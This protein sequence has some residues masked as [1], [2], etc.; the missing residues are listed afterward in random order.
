MGNKYDELKLNNYFLNENDIKDFVFI[1]DTCKKYINLIEIPSNKL[2]IY[3]RL[4]ISNL[5]YYSKE[6]LFITYDKILKM[7]NIKITKE[8]F[9]F[10]ISNLVINPDNSKIKMSEYH[11]NNVIKINKCIKNDI[12]NYF[13]LNK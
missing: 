9:S 11:I 13:K 1:L 2:N 5:A 8:Y 10:L 12:D 4:F 7:I 3:H 6:Y